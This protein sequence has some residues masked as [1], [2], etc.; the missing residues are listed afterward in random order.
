[1]TVSN[2]VPNPRDRESKERIRVA[3]NADHKGK[4]LA[5]C[6]NDLS[7]VENIVLYDWIQCQYQS[8]TTG[9]I[10]PLHVCHR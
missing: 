1:M 3:A 9:R 5:C 7:E 8:K 2:V 10:T 4:Y 6:K